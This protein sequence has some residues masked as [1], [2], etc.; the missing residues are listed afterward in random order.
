MGKQL[1]IK[2]QICRALEGQ[3]NICP[4]CESDDIYAISGYLPEEHLNTRCNNCGELFDRF[5]L[6]K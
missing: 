3:W 1:N 5:D 6:T 4:I 2:E